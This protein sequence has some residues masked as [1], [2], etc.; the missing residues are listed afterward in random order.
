MLLAK[1]G[2]HLVEVDLRGWHF[3]AGVLEVVLE[4]LEIAFV[5]LVNQMH[6]QIVEVIL[7]RMGT[8]RVRDLR[9]R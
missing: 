4:D 8:F 6:R 2:V 3:V 7:D 9:F 1:L 5:D